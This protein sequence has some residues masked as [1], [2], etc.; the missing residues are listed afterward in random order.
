[1]V[2]LCGGDELVE[3]FDILTQYSI[4]LFPVQEVQYLLFHVAI[5]FYISYSRYHVYEQIAYC[6]HCL[7]LRARLLDAVKQLLLFRIAR[8][9]RRHATYPCHPLCDL[10][11]FFWIAMVFH[12]HA[13]YHHYLHDVCFKL[14]YYLGT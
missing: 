9:F 13:L 6:D 1:M 11:L 5:A 10:L 14:L 2:V 3:Q 7:P 4:R 8:L 12:E